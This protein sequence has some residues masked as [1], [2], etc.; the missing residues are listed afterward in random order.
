MR[1]SITTARCLSLFV[2]LLSLAP[3]ASIYVT[4]SIL[5]N[6]DVVSRRASP[7]LLDAATATITKA[8]NVRDDATE[9][10]NGILKEHEQSGIG[11]ASSMSRNV[12]EAL[13]TLLSS[14]EEMMWIVLY[15]QIPPTQQQ[16][17]EEQGIS[18][19]TMSSSE[20]DIMDILQIQKNHHLPNIISMVV[21]WVISIFMALLLPCLQIWFGP[22]GHGNYSSHPGQRYQQQQRQGGWFGTMSKK[23]W[24]QKIDKALDLYQKRLAEDDWMLLVDVTCSATRIQNS[25]NNNNNSSGVDNADGNADGNVIDITTSGPLIHGLVEGWMIPLAG[26]PLR[27]E[28]CEQFHA[29]S[30][31]GSDVDDPH[32]RA[33]ENQWHPQSKRPVTEQCAI[34]LM[35]YKC[36]ETMVWSSNPDCMHN[37][38]YHCIL[39]WLLKRRNKETLPCPCCRRAFVIEEEATK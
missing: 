24:K 27:Q 9:M 7:S 14:I 12:T 4:F 34:C 25:E 28:D 3:L 16:Q 13:S 31:A 11:I 19:R 6:E 10:F 15:D 2:L 33:M 30:Y 18:T 8:D 29:S 22:Q 38:H 21:P 26:T 37:F 1:S 5:Q 36:G 20:N 32:I 23:Q 17:H 39:T 35:T